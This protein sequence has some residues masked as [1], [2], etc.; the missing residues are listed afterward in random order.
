M[1]S[2]PAA[3][4]LT[5]ALEDY[6]ETIQHF[7]DEKGFARVRDL[8]E[9]RGVKS[10]SAS[11]ALKRLADLGLINHRKGEFVTTTKEGESIARR[12]QAR[13]DLLIRFFQEF[14]R[15]EPS[16]AL[17]DACAIEHH[18]SDASMDKLTRLFE[19]LQNCPE[20]QNE[21]LARF[22][23][24]PIINHAK[25]PCTHH[26]KNHPGKGPM[27]SKGRPL[28]NLKVGELAQVVRVEAI[29]ETRKKLLNLGL[30][31]DAK[32]EIDRH[33]PE[34]GIRLLLNSHPVRLTTSEAR[35]ILVE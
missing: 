10:G 29:G 19:F 6:L 24:C 28:H 16:Q 1:P 11:P 35:S 13:H 33:D 7:V 17:E 15:V 26:C 4:Q 9:A 18:L 2:K 25:T 32:V 30:I 8:C 14:L 22:H 12:T 21:F 23:D 3:N 31:P 5:H 34:K 20:G 27:P